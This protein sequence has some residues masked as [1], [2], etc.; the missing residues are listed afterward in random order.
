MG[1]SILLRK[2]WADVIQRP[3]RTLLMVLAIAVAVGGITAVGQAGE[4]LGGAFFYSTDPGAVPNLILQFDAA[5]AGA[6]AGAGAA[7]P[8]DVASRL[9]QVPGV[10]TWEER[11]IYS[12][13]WEFAG[14]PADHSLQVFATVDDAAMPLWPFELISGRL[15]GSGEIGESDEIVLDVRNQ[16]EGDGVPLGATIS[17]AAPEGQKIPLRVVGISR[18]RGFALGGIFANPIG[19]MSAAGLASL[20]ALPGNRQPQPDGGHLAQQVLAQAPDSQVVQAYNAM[21]Q[22]VVA[23]H[24]R[25][26]TKSS[27]WRYSSGEAGAQLSVSGPVAVVQLLA[28]LAL[29]LVGVMLF[30]FVNMLLSEQV[31][32]IG[33]MKA[34]GGTRRRIT[35]SY[36]LQIGIYGLVGTAL[37]LQ[38]GLLAGY[39]LAARLASTVQLNV[40]SASAVLD[41]GPFALS[42]EATALGLFVGL[43]IPAGAALWPLWTGTRITVREALSTYAVRGPARTAVG[44]TPKREAAFFLTRVPQTVTLSLRNLWRRPGRAALTLLALTLAA[45]IFLAIQWADDSLGAIVNE[46]HS[47]IAHPDLRIDLGDRGQRLV[48]QVAALPNVHQVVPVTFADSVIGDHRM[49]LTGVPAERYQPP[50][51]AGRWL[52]SGEVGALVM[53]EDAARQVGLRV[54]DH[55]VLQ[56]DFVSTAGHAGTER[57]GV[58]IVGLLHAVDYLAGSADPE[59]TIGEAFLTQEWLNSIQGK[60]ADFADRLVVHAGDGAPAALQRLKDRIQV[61]LDADGFGQAGVRTI[62]EL[63]DGEVDTMPTIYGLFALVAGFVG[64]VG[65]LSLALTLTASVF[66]R[67]AEVGI[68]RALGATGRRV[69]AVFGLEGVLMA[70]LAWGVGSLLAVPGGLG[71]VGLL[72]HFLGPFDAVFDPLW[73]LAAL[74]FVVTVAVL[75]GVGPALTAARL[76][77][78]DVLRYE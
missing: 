36:L 69:A 75:A 19:Y 5:G 67:Q 20:S 58:T 7:L 74:G 78:R 66:E 3:G 68:L 13:P 17:V 55:L 2:A 50:I 8:S 24:L 70:L 15:P 4:Q 77:I 51:V 47:P 32:V 56:V 61:L 22:I 12:A 23:A 48:E 34:L 53:N 42:G 1:M 38:I 11:A 10:R 76:H 54:G 72:G 33:T 52:T 43:L 60:P 30:N 62:Q 40:G 9:R 71:L 49:F 26:N 44:R 16:L 25:L 59:A 35:A 31:A 21:T 46:E 64:L 6:G 29:L 65:L 18:T 37:G 28:G 39:H 73:L 41:A 27:R 63:T 45:A 14:H 57:A